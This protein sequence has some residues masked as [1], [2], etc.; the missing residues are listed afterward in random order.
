MFPLGESTLALDEEML[1]VLDSVERVKPTSCSEPTN[2]DAQ[3]EPASSAAPSPPLALI[4]HGEWEKEEPVLQP[5]VRESHRPFVTE[6]RVRGRIA[7]CKR[8]G[9]TA[10]CKALAQKLLFSE[11][12]EEAVCAQKGPAQVQAVPAGACINALTCQELELKNNSQAAI[13]HK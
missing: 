4:A 5:T 10:D 2:T 8:P 13:S 12:P 6:E 7:D 3:E 9:W 11:D 1:Q